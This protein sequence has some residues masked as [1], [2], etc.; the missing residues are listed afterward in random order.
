MASSCVVANS[1]NVT[2]VVVS[3]VIVVNVVIVAV[4][5]MNKIFLKVYLKCCYRGRVL[6]FLR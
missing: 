6:D 5:L 4:I 1:V 2:R 3:V